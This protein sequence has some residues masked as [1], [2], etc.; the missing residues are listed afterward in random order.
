MADNYWSFR[1]LILA[2]KEELK[3]PFDYE[4][5]MFQETCK[6]IAVVDWHSKPKPGEQF[7]RNLLLES[8]AIHTRI[9]IDFFYNDLFLSENKKKKTDRQDLNDI[10]AQDFMPKGMDWIQKRPE[11][12][13]TLY[14]AREKA[15]KQLAHLS[16]WRIKLD[17]D[18]GK[19]WDMY[20][21][22]KEDLEKV[23]EKF[24]LI[25]I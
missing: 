8:L 19:D 1:G 16:R 10:I 22:I 24:K 15:N 18:G 7:N 20:P 9:L 25:K 23:I 17:K 14:D 5:S 21:K 13:P 6:C 4:V 12:T 11:L 2:T 3:D